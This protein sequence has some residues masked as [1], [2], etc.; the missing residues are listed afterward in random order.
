MKREKKEEVV[1]E[2]RDVLARTR[3]AILADYKGL[4]VES[5]TQIR[6][7]L[8][9]AGIEFRV[10]KNTLARLASKETNI[11]KLNPFLKGPSALV[12]SYDDVVAPAKVMA[13]FTK[14]YQ[15]LQIKAGLL[16]GKVL[17]Q[18]EIG[19]L[20]K[21]P[22]REVLL[23]KLLSAMNGVPGGFVRL[24]ANVLQTFMGTLTAIRDQKESAQ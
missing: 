12:L 17:T 2:M 3:M 8:R 23:S 22:S 5:I 21:L 1:A 9:D 18:Q 13:E 4:N 14:K 16:E 7:S 20:A 10:V 15:R 11:E 6:N 19:D 24:L